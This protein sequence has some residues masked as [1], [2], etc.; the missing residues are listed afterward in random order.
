M[1]GRLM[2]TTSRISLTWQAW[3]SRCHI[4]DRLWTW[5]WIWNQV[6]VF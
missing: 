2:K 5:S 3:M 6:S 1:C 4:T